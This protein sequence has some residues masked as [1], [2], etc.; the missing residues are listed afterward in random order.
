VIW[1]SI[2]RH[3]RASDEELFLNRKETGRRR[4]NPKKAMSRKSRRSTFAAP[5]FP[6]LK[7]KEKSIAIRDFNF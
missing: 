2:Y 3:K 1:P 6:P 5:L 7:E 4:R